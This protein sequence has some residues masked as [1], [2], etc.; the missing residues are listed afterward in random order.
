MRTIENIEGSWIETVK[1]VRLLSLP[2]VTQTPCCCHTP[3][4]SSLLLCR[5]EEKACETG[6]RVQFQDITGKDL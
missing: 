1:K 3:S 4:L 5:S 6:K 2:I